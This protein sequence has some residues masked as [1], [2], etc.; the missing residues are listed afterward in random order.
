MLRDAQ[1]VRPPL[2][3]RVSVGKSAFGATLP[4]P[5]SASHQAPGRQ[6]PRKGASSRRAYASAATNFALE[7]PNRLMLG[8][9]GP[10]DHFGEEVVLSMD[11]ERVWADVPKAPAPDAGASTGAAAAGRTWRG[12]RP[13]DGVDTPRVATTRPR[14]YAAPAA[15]ECIMHVEMLLLRRNDLYEVLGFPSRQRLRENARRATKQNVVKTKGQCQRWNAY[16]A[17]VVVDV[18]DGEHRQPLTSWRTDDVSW[19]R[20]KQRKALLAKAARAMKMK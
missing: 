2:N 18:M 19:S 10:M 8:T 7:P 5:Q 16:M 11:N 20:A 12:R 1:P 9:L 3:R 6:S 17:G 4:R 14:R 13:M 15:F